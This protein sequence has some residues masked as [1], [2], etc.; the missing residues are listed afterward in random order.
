MLALE[1]EAA[2]NGCVMVDEVVSDCAL[3]TRAPRPQ[4]HAFFL[5]RLQG[6]QSLSYRGQAQNRQSLPL[7]QVP[8]FSEG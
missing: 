6:L 7:V 1:A 2:L 8:M 3:L 4:T 5:L